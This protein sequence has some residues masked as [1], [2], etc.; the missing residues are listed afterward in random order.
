M[1]VFSELRYPTTPMAK[2]FSGLLALLLFVLVALLSVSSYLLYEVLRPVKPPVS[3]FNFDTMIG[4]PSQFSFTVAGGG[5][6][7]GWFFPGL[8]GAPIII[9]CHGYQSQRVDVLTLVTALQ[10]HQFNVLTFDFLGNGTSPGTTT[11]GYKE[12]AELRA[13]MN[14]LAARDDVDAQH[15][16]L[17]GVDMGGYVALEVAASDSRVAALAVDDAYASPADMLQIQAKASGLTALPLVLKLS[18][19]GFR[20]LNYPYR[21]EPPVTARVPLII[22]PKLFITA[23]DRPALTDGTLALFDKAAQPKRLQRNSVGYRDMSDDDRKNYESQV[24]NFFLESISP[25]FRN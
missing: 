17:W 6:R 3:T 16:G 1:A 5:S 9:V 19:V 24:V 22:G 11:L 12:T 18:T 21:K 25:S 4:H 10:E 14:A 8:R 7:D 23:E 15:F 20:W 13:A 2:L